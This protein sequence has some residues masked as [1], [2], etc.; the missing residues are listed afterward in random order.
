[1]TP[2]KD[3]LSFIMPAPTYFKAQLGAMKSGYLSRWGLCPGA[4]LSG[5]AAMTHD[6]ALVRI[7]KDPDLNLDAG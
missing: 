1:M 3:H 4:F 7:Q 5:K 6:S 2:V